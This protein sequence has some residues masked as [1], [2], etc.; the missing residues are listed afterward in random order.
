MKIRLG[1]IYGIYDKYEG[2]FHPY[3]AILISNK[4]VYWLQGSTVK[5]VASNN[6]L[7]WREKQTNYFKEHDQL[8]YF[9][10][11]YH[12]TCLPYKTVFSARLAWNKD[13]QNQKKIGRISEHEYER[14]LRKMATTTLD[15]RNNVGITD[16]QYHEMIENHNGQYS[17]WTF[18][19]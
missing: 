15:D 17:H 2:G 9:L 10:Q 4:N 6:Y 11:D 18:S 12:G 14:L 13:L 8:F 1:D 16:E 7:F 19:E 5:I 3:L